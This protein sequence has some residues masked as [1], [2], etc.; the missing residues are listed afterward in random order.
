MGKPKKN[1]NGAKKGPADKKKS[2]PQPP[3]AISQQE[4]QDLLEQVKDLTLEEVQEEWRRYWWK[5]TGVG[6][7]L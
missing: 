7:C 1:T 6:C 5:R 4:Y 2:P 3:F